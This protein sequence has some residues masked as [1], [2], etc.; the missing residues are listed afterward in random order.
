MKFYFFNSYEQSHSGFQLT[1]ISTGAQQ[2]QWKQSLECSTPELSS[3]LFHSGARCLAGRSANGTDYFLLRGITVTDESQRKW[4]INLA[5]EGDESERGQ[6]T[7]LV[8][9]ILLEY[10]S[11]LSMLAGCFRVQDEELSYLLD[12]DAFW[13]YIQ[14]STTQAI[15]LSS[16]EKHSYVKPFLSFFS[17]LEKPRTNTVLLLVP[18]SSHSYFQR[19][20]PMFRQLKVVTTTP[21]GLFDDLL[22]RNPRPLGTVK[23]TVSF[24]AH[25]AAD[26]DKDKEA[27]QP[28][29]QIQSR[30]LALGLGAAAL[31]VAC[32]MIAV[33]MLRKR[34]PKEADR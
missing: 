15:P 8:R 26:K 16:Y 18:E 23:T 5:F 21:P 2:L 6:Y 13:N 30:Q 32:A 7:A 17:A 11:F 10:D 3:A 1:H 9:G 34:T 20:N 27:A 28:P 29:T 4:Y 12:A 14:Q 19:Q 33:Q 31:A 24:S 25:H 22:S